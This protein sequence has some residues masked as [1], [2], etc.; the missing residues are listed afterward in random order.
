MLKK[1]GVLAALLLAWTALAAGQGVHEIDSLPGLGSAVFALTGATVH[2]GTGQIMEDAVIVIRDG[3]IE[4]VGAN[5]Q[6]PPDARQIDLSGMHVYPGLIDALTENGLKGSGQRSQQGQGQRPGQGRRGPPG[7]S[8]SEEENPEGPGLYP[9]VQA[10]DLLDDGVGGKLSAWRESGVL[11][12][13]VAPSEGIFMGQTALINLGDH[14]NDQ[15]IVR[16]PT[17]MLLSYQGMGR[18]YPG[19]LMGVIA[20]Q[21]QTLLDARHY[22]DAWNIY[23]SNPR[24]LQRPETDRALEALQPAIGGQLQVI[25][26]ANQVRQVRRALAMAADHNL[27]AI[28]SGGF[29]AGQTTDELKQSGVPVIFSLKFPTR[30]KDQHPDFSEGLAALRYRINAPKQPAQLEEAGI[31]F[32][33]SSGGSRNAGD[34]LKG[35]RKVVEEGLAPQAALRAA[36]LSAAEILGADQ[37]LG[38]VEQGKI[39]NLMVTDKDL[40]DSSAAV[41]YVFVDGAKFDIPEKKKPTSKEG[42]EGLPVDVAGLWDVEVFTPEGSQSMQFDLQVSGTT[43]SGQVISPMLGEIEILDGTVEGASFSFKISVDMGSGPL[44]ISISGTVSGNEMDGSADVAG[45]GS[46]PLEGRKAPGRGR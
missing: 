2:D 7:G 8:G 42:G 21:R 1:F 5:L 24:G 29:E 43:L 22:G 3:L 39:A 36:T 14:E 20:H 13:N 25:F 28:I 9:H 15:L 27:K 12:V 18:S 34:F 46:A 32:A 37:Q 38:S 44:D 31:R 41:R 11:S 4:A 19:S 23:R 45:Q 16:S 6:I 35:M 17:A 26:P 30:P 10:A 33:F 40:F